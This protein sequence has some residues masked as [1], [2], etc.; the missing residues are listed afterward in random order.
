MALYYKCYTDLMDHWKSVIPEKIIDV[1]YEKFVSEPADTLKSVLSF[2]D[3]DPDETLLDQAPAAGLE[4]I[5]AGRETGPVNDFY[6]KYWKNYERQ[7]GPL[8]D[9]LGDLARV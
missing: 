4:T 2:L 7:I 8:I 5:E 1:Q 9:S 3:L 6:V